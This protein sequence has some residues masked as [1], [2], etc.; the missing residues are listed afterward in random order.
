MAT[1]T[2]PPGLDL[3]RLADW[4]ATALPCAPGPLS[5]RLI[6]GGRS[7]LTYEIGDGVRTWVLRRP[8]LGRVPAGA[9]D[10]GREYRVLSALADTAV[11]VPATYALCRDDT[12]IGAPFYVMEKVDGTAYRNATQLAP[13]GPERVRT[14]SLRLV[15]TLV[16]LHAVDP[17]AVGLADFGRAEGFLGRQVRRWRTQLASRDLP[18][19]DELGDRL[20][21]RV[22][23]ASTPGIV[24]GDYRLDNVLIDRFDRPAAVIDW[25]MATI[26]D[27][28]TDLALLV[29][30]QKLGTLPGGDVIADA[31]SAPGHLTED[32]VLAR[33]GALGGREP[34]HFGFHVGL[35][36]HKLAAIVEG[37]RRRHLLGQTVGAGFDRLGTLTEPLLEI[38]LAALRDDRS[39]RRTQVTVFAAASGQTPATS[40]DGAGRRS[41]TG[42]T[43]HPA[44]GNVQPLDLVDAHSGVEFGLGVHLDAR[45]DGD[46][47]RTALVLPGAE[48]VTENAA[49]V[50]A[51]A[52]DFSVVMP[53]HPGFGRSP[54][55]EWC[56]SV[57]DLAYL[58]LD[59]LDRS[60]LTGVTLVGLQFGGWVAMEM[61][62]RSCARLSRLVLVDSVGV[63]LGGPLDRDVADLFAAPHTELDRLLYAD[64]G[65]GL[66]DLG[67][68]R[69]KDVLEMARNEEALA[70][71]GWEP[72]LHNPRLTHW[73]RRV[74]VPAL[75]VWGGRDRVV[76]PGYGR[77]LAERIPGA[78]F[79][80]I[81]QAGHR[82]QVEC[83]E[84]VA[85][86]IA[87]LTG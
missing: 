39:S 37:I 20:A 49:F 44:G 17:A 3:T 8:P 79:E 53:S 87:G 72:Y 43:T 86:L 58:Y 67:R 5:A 18:A 66:G 41:G 78:R 62:V 76:A 82:A 23:E 14:V 48:R 64:P 73:L 84:D 34:A 16:A 10:V 11:P 57:D 26:G 40:Q 55:P 71:Y 80:Q 46:G 75:V 65:H 27:P 56:S 6:A 81:D 74:A 35:A 12:V 85:K 51:L 15:D 1:P 4:C 50:E 47:S 60:G 22:P 24:H 59:W 61:A 9:H 21:R 52:K 19:A 32:E 69:E 83:P 42:A 28:L 68:A 63:K 31:A 13:L 2:D 30:Y 29:A 54:R 70:T 25:E 7:N 36:C 45:V 33:Y 38:G 77:G